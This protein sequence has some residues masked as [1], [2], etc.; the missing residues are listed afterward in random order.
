M[1][2]MCMA[3]QA[4]LI[5]INIRASVLCPNATMIIGSSGAERPQVPFISLA[6]FLLIAF[7]LAWIAQ[8]P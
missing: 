8:R 5:Y 4:V 7:G 1:A 2:M 3:T 6:P